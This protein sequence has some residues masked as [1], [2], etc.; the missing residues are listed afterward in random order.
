MSVR[1]GAGGVF[2]RVSSCE[3]YDSVTRAARARSRCSKPSSSNRSRIRNATSTVRSPRTVTSSI[4]RGPYHDGPSPA[5]SD[6]GW[7]LVVEQA[8]PGL[9]VCFHRSRDDSALE[10]V[11]VRRRSDGP[12][13]VQASLPQFSDDSGERGVVVLLFEHSGVRLSPQLVQ[14]RYEA[15]QCDR[16]HVRSLAVP[17]YGREEGGLGRPPPLNRPLAL[18]ERGRSELRAAILWNGEWAT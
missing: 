2:F 18:A 4:D 5:L 8:Q 9:Q 6:E 16:C 12:I 7:G 10:S 3:T 15:L 1:L 11:R 13:G 14:L 17:P